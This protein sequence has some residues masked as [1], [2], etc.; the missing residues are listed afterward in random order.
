MATYAVVAD[1]TIAD[2][3]DLPLLEAP[4]QVGHTFWLQ[5]IDGVLS[6]SQNIDSGLKPLALD[7]STGKVAHRLKQCKSQREP[8]ARAC[9]FTRGR[10]PSVIDATAGLAQDGLLLAAMGADVTMIEQHP[11]IHALLD[12]ALMR[13]RSG[14]DWLQAILSRVTLIHDNSS[15]WLSTNEAG[16]IYLDPMY[17]ESGHQRS[18]KVKK[19]MQ[20]LRLL[21]DTETD[22]VALF[23]AALSA[24]TE[25]LV[26]KRPNWAEALSS[27]PAHSCYEGKTHHYDIYIKN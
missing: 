24:M 11:L 6:L 20:L 14:P 17:P 27:Q 16:V 12:D 7:F 22:H 8:L 5:R 15:D 1:G 18:A 25:R 23:D 19:G 10:I 9:G 4:P 21:P 13:S 26:V 2:R 3:Y